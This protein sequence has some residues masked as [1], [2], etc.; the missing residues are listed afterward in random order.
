VH[1][2]VTIRSVHEVPLSQRLSVDLQ[3]RV[4]IAFPIPVLIG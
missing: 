3:R 4:W 1:G 2:Y